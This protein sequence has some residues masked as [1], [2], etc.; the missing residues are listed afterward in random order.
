MPPSCKGRNYGS[1]L[2]LPSNAVLC[3]ASAGV[4]RVVFGAGGEKG[5][6]LCRSF[7]ELLGQTTTVDLGSY[8]LYDEREGGV[9]SPIGLPL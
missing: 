8:R 9:Q 7:G 2:G 4:R 3:R 1:F 5:A 6:L